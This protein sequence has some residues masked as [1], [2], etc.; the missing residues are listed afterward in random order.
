MAETPKRVRLSAASCPA[1]GVAGVLKNIVYG[2][3]NSR[4]SRTIMF[5]WVMRTITMRAARSGSLS[6]LLQ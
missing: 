6:L 1:C 4:S 3:P 5:F 2:M